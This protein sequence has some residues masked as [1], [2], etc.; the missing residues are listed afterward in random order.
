MSAVALPPVALP[1]VARPPVAPSSRAAFS[2]P[3]TSSPCNCHRRDALPFACLPLVSLPVVALPFVPLPLGSLSLVAL[4]LGTL[5]DQPT[6]SSSTFYRVD[7]VGL[8]VAGQDL[9]L[10]A[11]IFET[12]EEGSFRGSILDSGTTFTLL[13][14]DAWT[15]LA[16][17][18]GDAVGVQF[19]E[20]GGYSCLGLRR[21]LTF[22]DLDALFPMVAMVFG[23]GTAWDLPPSSYL[24]FNVSFAGARNGLTCGSP[25]A[26]PSWMR[27]FFVLHDRS[28]NRIGF[29]PFNCTSLQ[30]LSA[31]DGPAAPPTE[32][33]VAGADDSTA[34][35]HQTQV[36]MPWIAASTCE[37]PRG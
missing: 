10:D 24:F 26:P 14:T 29:V 28:N 33:P 18:V 17:A 1:P 37:L 3:R 30:P 16:A 9:P 15:A 21:P 35:P 23:N 20:V 2:T 8:Q 22:E 27:N 34:G 4:P 36:D 13:P 32:N 11:S 12:D 19:F 5:L 6:I 7:L 25:K 31:V